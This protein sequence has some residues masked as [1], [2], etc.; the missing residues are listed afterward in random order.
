[1]CSASRDPIETALKPLN[2]IRVVALEQAVAAPFCTSR[3]ADAGARVIKIERPEGDF[4]RNYDDAAAGLSS[5]FVWLNR[6]K[7]SV[8]LDLAD[9]ESLKS[10][11]RLLES[12]DILVQ[13]LKPGALGRLGFSAEMLRRNYP[14]LIVCSITGYGTSG[15]L[16]SRKAYD[17]LVQAESGLASI[18][19]GADGPARVGFSVV[20]IATGATAHAA[21]L[22]ALLERERRGHAAHIDISMFD[23]MA[24]WL[25]VPLLQAEAG[26]H[27]QRIGLAHPS[28][29]PYG[30]FET[31]EGRSVL[32][33][34][35]NERE[36]RAFCKDVLQSEA[37]ASD[38]HFASNVQR[39]RNRPELDATVARLF[40]SLGHA[41]TLARLEAAD[42]AFAE[43]NDM[44]DLSRHPHLRRIEVQGAGVS[45]YPAPA[46]IF[47]GKTREA[48]PVPVLGAQST[49]IGR[50]LEE[51]RTAQG[52]EQS[53]DTESLRRW[54]GRTQEQEDLITPRIIDEFASVFGPTG[55]PAGLLGLHWCLAVPAA[56][57]G[58]LDRDGHLQRG[59]FLPPVP[60]PRR[61]WAG[62]RIEF[63]RELTPGSAIKRRSRIADLAVKS[64]RSGTLCIVNIAHEFISS[65]EVLLREEQDIIYRG[66]AS[67][68]QP[69]EPPSEPQPMEGATLIDTS[70]VL[71]F[72]YSAMTFNAHRIHYDAPY[73]KQDEGYPGLVVHGPLQ[74]T[75]LLRKSAEVLGRAPKR[76]SFRGVRPLI[77]PAV[78]SVHAALSG[79]TVSAHVAAPT[80]HITMT[81][82]AG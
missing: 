75:Y 40:Q 34:I 59:D 74:A 2:G 22:E 57:M 78:F 19:G 65:G 61:M 38:P 53:I 5:Y 17:L 37:T 39:V 58:A 28:I 82:D 21:V 80:G 72:R 81:S 69:A 3:L 33:S 79:E 16:A 77:A 4:A 18:T 10:F 32:I 35:Q 70:P 13:N 66:A 6:G 49:A 7:E 42:I 73:A 11:G 15:P 67:T 60:L 1:M 24:D 20:D 36:W 54:I 62:S 31:G 29:A 30:L 55:S 45:S 50:S 23:V 68:P 26:K 76:F 27:P 51:E 8:V 44:H 64:G 43:V 47:D 63:L 46:P 48:G 56:P 9:Q 12:A 52:M 25:T 14:R 41:G 71:L